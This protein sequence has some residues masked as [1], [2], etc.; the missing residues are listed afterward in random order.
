MFF[1]CISLNA[2]EFLL[3]LPVE[4][5]LLELAIQYTDINNTGEDHTANI[6]LK[7]DHYKRFVMQHIQM[8]GIYFFI[9]FYRF[10]WTHSLHK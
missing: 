10:S 3:L 2:N 5:C 8:Y 9:L 6:S 7:T 4:G 1:V